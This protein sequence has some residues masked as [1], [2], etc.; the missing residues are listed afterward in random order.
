MFKAAIR[1][2]RKIVDKYVTLSTQKY[3][4]CLRG[5]PHQRNY[6]T[7]HVPCRHTCL[8]IYYTVLS[9]KCCVSFFELTFWVS[10]VQVNQNGKTRSPIVSLIMPAR[11][12]VR[13]SLY[14]SSYS[15]NTFPKMKR[16]QRPL[17]CL[18]LLI[19]VSCDQLHIWLTS[20]CNWWE[21]L[22]RAVA[23]TKFDR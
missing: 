7:G 11:S 15:T 9:E 23:V 10:T 4:G 8:Y 20:F 16:S 5:R 6:N 14:S 18:S 22:R 2:F 17:F 1:A 19:G 3:S 12:Q 13:E 21:H